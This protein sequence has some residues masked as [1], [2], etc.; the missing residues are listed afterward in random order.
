MYL[1][2]GLA[3]YLKSHWYSGKMT[4]VRQIIKDFQ[5]WTTPAEKCLVKLI[6]WCHIYYDFCKGPW[7]ISRIHIFYSKAEKKKWEMSHC[8]CRME[9]NM[10]VSAGCRKSRAPLGQNKGDTNC[11]T[12]ANTVIDWRSCNDTWQ[13]RIYKGAPPARA[14]PFWKSNSRFWK[15]RSRAFQRCLAH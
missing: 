12:V 1:E 9:K 14:P 7:P 15:L 10:P 11:P 5:E 2:L 3:L 6:V 4:S 13:W 8:Q